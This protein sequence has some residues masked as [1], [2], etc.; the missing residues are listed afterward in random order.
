MGKYLIMKNY[1][2]VLLILLLGCSN[3]SPNFKAVDQNVYINKSFTNPLNIPFLNE[4]ANYFEDEF[5][6]NYLVRSK[7]SKSE[8]Q[9]RIKHFTDGIVDFS[10]QNDGTFIAHGYK[11]VKVLLRGSMQA[12][13]FDEATTLTKHLLSQ[14]DNF[15]NSKNY[16]SAKKNFYRGNFTSDLR[17]FLRLKNSIG[18]GNNVADALIPILTFCN[19]K[20]IYDF[21]NLEQFFTNSYVIETQSFLDKKLEIKSEFDELSSMFQN[22]LND[23]NKDFFKP[24]KKTE[25]V[26][27]GED[28]NTDSYNMYRSAGVDP[29]LAMT[30]SKVST[31]YNREI[32]V[33][34]RVYLSHSE[35]IEPSWDEIK[36]HFGGLQGLMDRGISKDT[37]VKLSYVA[38]MIEFSYE[39]ESN[40]IIAAL[41]ISL[42]PSSLGKEFYSDLLKNGNKIKI[43]GEARLE[44][45]YFHISNIHD[46]TKK[47]HDM[48]Y[49]NDLM[50]EQPLI[51]ECIFPENPTEKTRFEIPLELIRDNDI[52]KNDL[53]KLKS[54]FSD[55]VELIFNKVPY[56]KYFKEHNRVVVFFSSD[57]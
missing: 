20:L 53:K 21:D 22:Y 55:E 13:S 26:K 48:N 56:T 45:N 38:N 3:T 11:N 10:L 15:E 46:S 54:L 14:K 41:Y 34:R 39:N 4:F 30:F 51:F 49:F 50:I 9:I 44:K 43:I 24:Y 8:N 17:Q 42:N 29:L 57:K 31:G 12:R 40:K 47:I 27:T 52:Y 1:I 5:A 19:D 7:V 33:M 2:L 25:F 36:E 18:Y 32:E 23:K 28:Y 35:T 6:K 16:I 37:P